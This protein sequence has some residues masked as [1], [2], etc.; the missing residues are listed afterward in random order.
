MEFKL[1]I[2]QFTRRRFRNDLLVSP[3]NDRLRECLFLL[4][5]TAQHHSAVRPSSGPPSLLKPRELT[6]TFHT[7]N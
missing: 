4:M 3:L 6:L 7:R 2:S 1:L 5:S